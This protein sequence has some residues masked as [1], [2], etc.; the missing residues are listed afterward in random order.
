MPRSIP[1]L[2]LALVGPGLVAPGIR[3]QCRPGALPASYGQPLAD[4]LAIGLK[5]SRI[6]V[7]GEQRE[8]RVPNTLLEPDYRRV[9]TEEARGRGERLT[10]PWTW[11]WLPRWAW[12]NWTIADHLA[13]SR[14]QRLLLGEPAPAPARLVIVGCGARKRTTISDAGNMYIGSYHRAARRAADALLRPGDRVMILSAKHGLL[15]LDDPIRPYELR[16][17][18]AGAVDADTVRRQAEELGL[19]AA[20]EVIVLAGKAYADMVTAVW[21]HALRPLDG[22]AGLGHQLHRLATIANTTSVDLWAGTAASGLGSPDLD[23]PPAGSRRRSRRETCLDASRR[24]APPPAGCL[25]STPPT[26]GPRRCQQHRTGASTERNSAMSSSITTATPT[27]SCQA[28]LCDLR[29]GEALR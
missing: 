11:Q 18:Q 23:E 14:G 15:A 24:A 12:L 1:S 4:V 29:A 10:N 21:P 7:C 2:Q 3:V 9:A 27:D 5:A 26:V 16:L 8:R 28:S 13:H 22:Y 19:L 25:M 6:R 17:G 20:G